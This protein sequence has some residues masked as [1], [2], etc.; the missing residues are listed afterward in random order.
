MLDASGEDGDPGEFLEPFSYYELRLDPWSGS[1]CHSETVIATGLDELRWAHKQMLRPHILNPPTDPTPQLHVGGEAG[2]FI[3]LEGAFDLGNVLIPPLTGT[4]LP[5][6]H[7][8][9]GGLAHYGY[10]CYRG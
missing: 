10:S 6:G 1:S 3:K 4:P 7:P 9:Q 8:V 5:L 2:P